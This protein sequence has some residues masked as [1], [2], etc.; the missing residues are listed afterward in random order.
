MSYFWLRLLTDFHDFFQNF[1]IFIIKDSRGRI[2]NFQLKLEILFF[3]HFRKNFRIKS[4]SIFSKLG[5]KERQCNTDEKVG[6]RQD[7]ILIEA[8]YFD[9]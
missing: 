4:A 7:D 3:G 2:L 8:L 5:S 1:F 6:L 9:F